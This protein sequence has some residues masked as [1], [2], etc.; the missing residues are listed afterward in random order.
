MGGSLEFDIHPETRQHALR[1]S[2][3]FDEFKMYAGYEDTAFT[4]ANKLGEI[5]LQIG[6]GCDAP[7]IDR[8]ALRRPDPLG[9]YPE[10]QNQMGSR[11]NK[12]R[13]W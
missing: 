9:R 7:E 13:G 12:C 1:E 10:R 4:L 6:Q 8:I 5:L 11:S 2:G 3:L